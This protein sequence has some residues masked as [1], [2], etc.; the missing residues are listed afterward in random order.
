M[1]SLKKISQS[2]EEIA[3]DIFRRLLLK[4]HNDKSENC[5]KTYRPSDHHSNNHAKFEENLSKQGRVNER[6]IFMG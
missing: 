4:S 6:H 2:K 5:Q 1:Q 3:S